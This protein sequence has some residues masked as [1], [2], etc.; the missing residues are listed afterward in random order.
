MVGAVAGSLH[1]Q[2]SYCQFNG[3]LGRSLDEHLNQLRWLI[4]ADAMMDG[5]D[6]SAPS[7]LHLFRARARL[8]TKDS[9]ARRATVAR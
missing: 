5:G 2:G 9:T 7:T 6:G 8:Q 4:D 1:R 3:N